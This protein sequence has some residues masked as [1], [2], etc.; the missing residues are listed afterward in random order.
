MVKPGLLVLYYV[1]TGLDCTPAD[2]HGQ[3]IRRSFGKPAGIKRCHPCILQK[4]LCNQ[5]IISEK[6]AGTNETRPPLAFFCH[7]S[8][9]SEVSGV[10]PVTGA[11]WGS[12]TNRLRDHFIAD[13]DHLP[14]EDQRATV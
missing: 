6:T 8:G 4:T 5:T 11:D 3:Y 12:E 1:G 9:I 14:E 13:R 2:V 10:L 7:T